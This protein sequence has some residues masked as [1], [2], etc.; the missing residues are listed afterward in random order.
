[1]YI[2]KYQ[3]T[4]INFYIYIF[5]SYYGSWM[6]TNKIIIELTKLKREIIRDKH[7]CPLRVIAYPS[8]VQYL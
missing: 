4:Y 1:M 7:V 2:S 8:T 5:P 6:K 3:C